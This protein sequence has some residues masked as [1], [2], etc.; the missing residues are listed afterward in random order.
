MREIAMR[1]GRAMP[2]LGQ[3]TWMMGAGAAAHDREV[4][5][6]RL[7]LDLGMSLIDTAEMYADGGAERVVADAIRG[8]REEVYLVSKVL[9]EN[10]SREGTIRACEASL[11]RLGTDRIDLYLLHWRGRYRLAETAEAFQRLREAGKILSFG[12][13]NFD[14]DDLAEW[15]VAAGEPPAS[16]QILYNLSR[17]GPE[18]AVIPWC[19]GQGCTVMAYSPVEQGRMIGDPRL[20]EIARGL[21]VTPAQLAIAWLLRDPLVSV[22]PKASSPDHVRENR[23]AHDLVLSEDVVAALDRAFPLSPKAGLETV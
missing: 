16:N 19:R 9:P 8:R 1:Q 20:S 12:V 10:A 22:I 2:V 21:G 4:T 14:A 6:L 23:A 15:T 17:R 3:G 13:S 18:N 7:G 5:A 11:K